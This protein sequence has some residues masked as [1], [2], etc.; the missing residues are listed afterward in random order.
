MAFSAH[1]SRDKRDRNSSAEE[2]ARMYVS[3]TISVIVLFGTLFIGV[4]YIVRAEL[5]TVKVQLD[6]CLEA[7]YA[8]GA[9]SD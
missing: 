8:K 2:E 3:A 6:S 4:G 1:D 7:V 9:F 5:A